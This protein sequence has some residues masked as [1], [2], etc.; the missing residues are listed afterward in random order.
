MNDWSI[1]FSEADLKRSNRLIKI[2]HE[3]VR[4]FFHRI[5]K[6]EKIS[7]CTQLCVPSKIY[8]MVLEAIIR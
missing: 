7:L 2:T 5:E 4:V 6:C 8:L 1:V 3:I